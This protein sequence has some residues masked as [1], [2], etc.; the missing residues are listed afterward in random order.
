MSVTVHDDDDDDD[1][2][3]EREYDAFMSRSKYVRDAL[4]AYTLVDG[5]TPASCRNAG[6]DSSTRETS[7]AG[8]EHNMSWRL[9]FALSRRRIEDDPH[10]A[11]M[12][13]ELGCELFHAGEFAA[14][15]FALTVPCVLDAYGGACEPRLWLRLA[16]CSLALGGDVRERV[17][18]VFDC[19]DAL[20][21]TDGDEKVKRI[22]AT[23]ALDAALVERLWARRRKCECRR[24]TEGA[25]LDAMSVLKRVDT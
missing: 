8:L 4:E 24:R 10:E 16:H 2:D 23:I 9:A 1:D 22:K 11:R 25:F 13:Y 17:D 5:D 14:C 21:L 12:W 3:G 19:L 6:G 18:N 20:K 15:E 7:A